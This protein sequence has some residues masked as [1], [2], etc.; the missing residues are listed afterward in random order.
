M[1]AA[2][3]LSLRAALEP[4]D[5][6]RVREIVRSTGFFSQ[7]EEDIAAELVCE[8]LERGEASGYAFLFLSCAGRCAAYACFGRIAGTE[9]S[10]DLYWIATHADLRGRGLGR[11]LIAAAEERIARRGGTRVYVETSSRA[12]YEPTR[13][14]YERCGYLEAAVL[15]DFYRPGDGKVVFCKVVA[16]ATG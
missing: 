2:T 5:E 4:E 3:S 6:A 13:R 15:P 12:Q 11:H 1:D 8:A 14:F 7:E 16:A 10:F 9:S